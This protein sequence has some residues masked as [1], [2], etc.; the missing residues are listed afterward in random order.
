MDDDQLKQIIDEI[1]EVQG[2]LSVVCF[3]LGLILALL[4]LI[5]IGW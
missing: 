4:I 1:K 2:M 5:K 3:V